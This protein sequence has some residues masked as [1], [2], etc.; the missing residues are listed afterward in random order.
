MEQ[1]EQVPYWQK[2]KNSSP[3]VIYGGHFQEFRKRGGTENLA[4]I[5]GFG[6]TCHITD[7]NF[8]L[9]RDTVS[10][11]KKHFLIKLMEK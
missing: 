8:K 1:K 4:G 9:H 3:H 5:V 11:Y 7:L 6:M 10:I 2:E